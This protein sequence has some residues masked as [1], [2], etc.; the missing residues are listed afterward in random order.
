MCVAAGSLAIVVASDGSASP[1]QAGPG[2]WLASSNGVVKAFG[3]A[4]RLRLAEDDRRRPGGGY[5]PYP[6]AGGYWLATAH[7][8][9]YG[10]GDA[11]VYGSM[12]TC[13]LGQ[14]HRGHHQGPRWA[15]GYWLFGV[16]GGVF[17]FG[18]AGYF[19]SAGA[20]HLGAAVVGM[21]V[22]P[23]G[24]GYLLATSK[25]GRPAL[26]GGARGGAKVAT[27][28][29]LAVAAM[30]ATPD[31]KG[32]WLVTTQG[33]GGAVRRRPQLRLHD[34]GAQGRHRGHSPHRQRQ[35]LLAG[36]PGR[37]RVRLRRR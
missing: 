13:A 15:G 36:G 9:V 22:A 10:F 5:R 25:G 3:G 20:S 27:P 31:A 12:A 23:A 28:L 11:K 32:Y 7:G 6:D 29:G 14:G 24:R 26:V 8:R 18:D 34:R 4:G 16:D 1:A 19:G 30:A 17:A 33:Q 2:F 35:G 37:G 21:A